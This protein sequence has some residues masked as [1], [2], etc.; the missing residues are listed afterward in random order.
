MVDQI[1]QAVMMSGEQTGMM[2]PPGAQIENRDI[3][4]DGNTEHPF[5]E[6]AREQSR[7]TTQV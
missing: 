5:V 1:A 7:E 3:N 6:R 4:L 2:L